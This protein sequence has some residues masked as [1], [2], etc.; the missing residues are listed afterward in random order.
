MCAYYAS[1]G[2]SVE[3]MIR[4]AR[5]IHGGSLLNHAWS[6][7]SR[8]SRQAGGGLAEKVLQPLSGGAFRPLHRG[9]EAIGIT[10][11]DLVRRR[12]ILLTGKGEDGDVTLAEAAI[13]GSAIPVLFPSKRVR[14]GDRRYRLIDA[15]F[16]DA[17]PVEAALRPPFGPGKVVV[18]DLSLRLGIR[19]HRPGYWRSL[20]ERLADRLV[21]L[22]PKVKRFGTVLFLRRDIDRIL[23]AGREVVTAEIVN[24]LKPE[25]QNRSPSPPPLDRRNPNQ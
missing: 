14:H 21:L 18:V 4:I 9:I 7:W 2:Y 13:G 5:S 16:L 11:F 15:G 24:R 10:A 25:S 6:Q 17:V 22:R 19:Q 1:L 3:D 20:R 23:S 8:G 12:E